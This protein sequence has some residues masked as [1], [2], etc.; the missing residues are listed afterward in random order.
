MA[1]TTHPTHHY[2]EMGLAQT[3]QPVQT[4]PPRHSPRYRLSCQKHVCDSAWLSFFL[5]MQ[6]TRGHK[7][8]SK[9]HNG[10]QIPYVNS[11]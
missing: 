11:S 5:D 1:S 6:K 3:L 4:L 10:T 8:T 2:W 7:T 9:K